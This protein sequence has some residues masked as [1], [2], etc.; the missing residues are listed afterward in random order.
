M[1]KSFENSKGFLFEINLAVPQER[2]PPDFPFP[3]QPESTVNSDW[4]EWIFAEVLTWKSM[5]MF[6]LY[7]FK[8][9]GKTTIDRKYLFIGR[10]TY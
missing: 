8:C 10:N 9:T 5:R 1:A 4:R 7:I 6:F 2:K 3:S